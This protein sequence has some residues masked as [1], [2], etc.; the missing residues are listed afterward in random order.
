MSEA[1]IFASRSS[2]LKLMPPMPSILTT[3]LML[4]HYMPTI[5]ML[6]L[7]LAL[8]VTVEPSQIQ[9]WV[10][11]RYQI[12]TNGYAAFT[13]VFAVVSLYIARFPG[14]L[15]RMPVLDFALTIL[16]TFPLVLYIISAW[17]YITVVVPNGSKVF[18]WLYTDAYL[19]LLLLYA[20]NIGLRLWYASLG[21]WVK[22]KYSERGSNE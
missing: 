9:T 13:L 18:A 21:A 8:A 20:I 14:A 15:K 12:T 3:A 4:I 22:Q 2:V 7:S 10:N 17:Y 6:G 11:E 19:K 1:P 16:L 5:T